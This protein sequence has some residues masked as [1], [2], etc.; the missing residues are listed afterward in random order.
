MN[1]PDPNSPLSSLPRRDQDFR[2]R[3]RRRGQL[4]IP[5]DADGRAALI[6][7]LAHR[8][9]PTYELFVFAALSGSILALGYLMDSQ[10]L[11]LFGVLVAPLLVPWIGL[12]L[13]TLTGSLRF[14]FETLMALLLSALI[15]FAI[16]LLAGFAARL[17]LPRTFDQAFAHSRLWW[18][19]LIILALGAVILTVSFV[20]S[21]AKP[22]LPSVVLAYEFFLPLASGGFGL[23]S[24]LE[25]LWPQGLLVF[26][27]HFAWASIFG[28]STLLALR[29]SPPNAA[30]YVFS[31]AVG[32]VLLA[33]L[34]VLMSGG[35]WTTPF[36]AQPPGSSPTSSGDPASSGVTS[37]EAT[38]VA[39]LSSPTAVV[40]A[41]TPTPPLVSPT[42]T[43]AA[44]LTPTITMT[45]EPTP[46]YAQVNA[47]R[48]GAVL[49]MTPGGDGITT[50][51]NFTYV[52]LLPETDDFSG[53][54]W[55]HVIAITNGDRREGWIVQQYLDTSAGIPTGTP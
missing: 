40:A 44:T 31:A 54:T 15:V 37:P 2:S 55:V 5:H 52:E 51:D 38:T 36:A 11:L 18:P 30:A 20:R 9:Y 13:G 4:N 53:Y 50:L 3:R 23:G 42:P 22:F 33:V 47:P 43:R 27:V 48:G 26:V 34:V 49:R 17:F 39:L 16:G 10:A 12:L 41:A 19:D 24:G 14:V 45:I 46:V 25:G 8:A 6:A 21:E 29:I 35:N 28:L 1:T 7:S 32:L